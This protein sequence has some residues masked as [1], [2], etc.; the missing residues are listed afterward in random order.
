M[1]NE[2]EG[3]ILRRALIDI[4]ETINEASDH[5]LAACAETCRVCMPPTNT[6]T[7]LAFKYY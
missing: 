2:E 7:C 4:I 1:S 3:F 5:Y 6:N